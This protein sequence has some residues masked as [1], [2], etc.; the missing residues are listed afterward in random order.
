MFDIKWIRAN[1]DLF[2]R[3]LARRGAAPMAKALIALDDERKKTVQQLNEWQ[4]TRN[5]SSKQ[6]GQAKAQGDEDKAQAFWLKSPT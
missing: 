1:P 6:I 2:D 3:S 4:G 5:S